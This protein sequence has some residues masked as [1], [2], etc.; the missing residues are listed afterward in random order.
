MDYILTSDKLT[1]T[2]GQ[3]DA[4]KDVSLHIR[5]GDIYGLI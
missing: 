5:Q 2:Y 3:K 1:K 4:A